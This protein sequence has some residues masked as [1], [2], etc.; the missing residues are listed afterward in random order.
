MK[1]QIQIGGDCDRDNQSRLFPQPK[2]RVSLTTFFA[3]CPD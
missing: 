3:S 2:L 1:V